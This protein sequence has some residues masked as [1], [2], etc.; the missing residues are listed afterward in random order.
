MLT[1]I[2]KITRSNTWKY[3]IGCAKLFIQMSERSH[4]ATWNIE[5]VEYS[6]ECIVLLTRIWKDQSNTWKYCIGCMRPHN[7]IY[8]GTHLNVENYSLEYL[9][10]LHQMHGVIHSNARE[11]SPLTIWNAYMEVKTQIIECA[12]HIRGCVELLNRTYENTQS[13]T[14]GILSNAWNTQSHMWRYL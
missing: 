7:W 5:Y 1:W 6:L 13:N 9:E 10:I 11:R 8:E 2:C 14:W 4:V 12:K 3:S